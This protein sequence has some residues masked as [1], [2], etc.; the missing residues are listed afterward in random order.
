MEY[1]FDVIVI[2]SGAGGGTMAVACARAGRRVLLL[3]RGRELSAGERR[4]LHGSEQLTLIDKRPYDD[5]L[6]HTDDG[7]RRLYM[8]G[9]TGGG[10]SLFGGALLRP[11]RA[12]FEPGRSYGDR[13][14]R[15][16]HEWPVSYDELAPWY[17][18]AEH[19]LHVT[20]HP[21]DRLAP[22]EPPV[23]RE[24][25]EVLPLAEINQHLMTRTREAGWNPFRL[26]L[27]IRAD[28]CL[29]CDRCAGFPCPN[30]SRRSTA[31][32]VAEG[33]AEGLPI[34][35]WSGCEAERFQRRPGNL[36]E[37]LHLK[38]PG[39]R[40]ERIRARTYVLAAGAIGSASL[41]LKSRFDHPLIGKNYMTHYS[42]VVAGIFPG[43]TGADREFVKQVG[44]ADFYFGTKDCREKLGIVQ[45]L[46]A[47]GPLMLARSGL[48]R[49]PHWFTSRLRGHLLPLAGT[50]EDL[51][52]PANR[53][54]LRPDGRVQL[55]HEFSTY[56]RR[57][58]TALVTAMKSLLRN[59][60]A[61]FCPGSEMPVREHVG[62]QCGTIRFGRTREHAVV[63]T[64]CRMFDQP[65]V[66]VADG[67][68]FPTSLGVGPA[69]TIAANAL[70]VAS[71]IS[72][73]L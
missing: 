4:E 22:L 29:R 3:D 10:T 58:G 19:L 1:D 26:P 14:P 49:A 47:P 62:H 52:N 31:Q 59:S 67:S 48:K 65:D 43:R 73:D 21:E 71:R 63:D 6:I 2:G 70:R 25:S 50:I 28:T 55:T 51:P 8:G 64:D 11:S 36:V 60:G 33:I 68:V 66:F 46:P 18:E 23:R 40:R 35:L 54:S 17:D 56:D 53:V 45:S 38:D 27:A 57:R 16:L 12:D 15:E 20:G 37:S 39:G 72:H 34:T 42:P 5:R 13:L 44:F 61:A 24:A 7:E 9:V 32:V 41:L 69:L 30:G